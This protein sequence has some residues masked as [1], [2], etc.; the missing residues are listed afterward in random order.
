M[1]KLTNIEDLLVKVI[2]TT[3][4]MDPGEAPESERPTPLYLELRK[5]LRKKSMSR[6]LSN[7]D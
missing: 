5:Q 4:H 1:H 6:L 3:A 2:Y 7:F